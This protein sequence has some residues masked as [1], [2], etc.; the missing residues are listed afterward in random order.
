MLKQTQNYTTWT[1]LQ[2][3]IDAKA[4]TRGKFTIIRKSNEKMKYNEARSANTS[5]EALELVQQFE[6]D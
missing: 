3:I 6:R 5:I 2:P 1:L 4:P